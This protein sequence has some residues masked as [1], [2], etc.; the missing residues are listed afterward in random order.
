LRNW[1]AES[2]RAHHLL[3]RISMF[4]TLNRI[5]TC[6]VCIC[7][8]AGSGTVLVV[9]VSVMVVLAVVCKMVVLAVVAVNMVVLVVNTVTVPVLSTA[10][11]LKA[12]LGPTVVWQCWVL[13]CQSCLRLK[14]N[15]VEAKEAQR[16]AMSVKLA[17]LFETILGNLEMKGPYGK[18]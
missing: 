14:E 17:V 1:Q 6:V 13:N 18:A 8:V 12:L 9:M 15:F 3:W 16:K 4:V 11:G 5:E 10:A 2:A 7:T